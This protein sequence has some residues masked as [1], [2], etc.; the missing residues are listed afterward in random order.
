[1]TANWFFGGAGR[2]AFLPAFLPTGRPAFLPACLPAYIPYQMYTEFAV[3][4][5]ADYFRRN[6]QRAEY[7]RGIIQRA[8]NIPAEL[9]SAR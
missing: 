9:F 8:L 1:V 5:N 2:P 6:I 3:L 7:S 4:T